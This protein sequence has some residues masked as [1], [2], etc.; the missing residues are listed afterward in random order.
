VSN[1]TTCFTTHNLQNT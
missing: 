1:L